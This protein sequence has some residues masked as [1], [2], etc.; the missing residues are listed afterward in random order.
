MKQEVKTAK[1]MKKSEIKLKRLNETARCSFVAV[2]KQQLSPKGIN[3]V[4]SFA[5]KHRENKKCE[6]TMGASKKERV[7]KFE[8]KLFKYARLLVGFAF[9]SFGAARISSAFVFCSFFLVTAAKQIAN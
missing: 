2:D 9:N 6:T 4:K 8:G 1:G 7:A 5:L 3:L